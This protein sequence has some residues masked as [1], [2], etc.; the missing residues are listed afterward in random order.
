MGMLEALRFI[1]RLVESRRKRPG[2]SP[3]PSPALLGPRDRRAIRPGRL[4]PSVAALSWLPSRGFGLV[5]A[6]LIFSL[7]FL[8]GGGETCSLSSVWRAAAGRGS[9][10][11]AGLPVRVRGNTGMRRRMPRG[12]KA[13]DVHLVTSSTGDVGKWPSRG[14]RK[15]KETGPTDPKILPHAATH[16][17]PLHPHSTRNTSTM[18]LAGCRSGAGAGKLFL[19]TRTTAGAATPSTLG[20]VAVGRSSASST[21]HPLTMAA[22]LGSRRHISNKLFI[23]GTCVWWAG[24]VMHACV[25]LRPPLTAC[26]S[27]PPPTHPVVPPATTADSLHDFFKSYGAIRDGAYDL[28]V[29]LRGVWSMASC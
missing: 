20:A 10:L 15:R 5:T 19:A 23:G 6:A 16:A 3:S 4:L 26:T 2:G 11:L 8:G 13:R 12:R 25:L 7:L 14:T 9:P 29:C 17:S 22:A 24:W 21:A 27:P 28:C 1:C 18:M